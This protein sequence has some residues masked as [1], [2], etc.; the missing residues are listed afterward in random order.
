MLTNAIGLATFAVLA[1][2]HIDVDGM[3]KAVAPA[4]DFFAYTNGTWVKKTTIPADKPGVGLDE[5]LDE[6]ARAQTAELIKAAAAST[7]STAEE[8]KV[9]DYYNT[10]M[11]EAGIE[12]LGK[13]P[14]EGELADVAAIADKKALSR[15]IGASLRADVDALN[16]TDFHTPNLLGVWV[17]QALDDP[18]HN[19][20]YLM[21]GGILMPEREYYVSTKPDMVELRKKYAAHAAAMLKLAGVAKSDD[22]ANAMAA[23]IVALETKI[24]EAHADL[25][26][27]QDVHQPKAVAVADLATTAPGLD[28]SAFFEGARLPTNTKSVWFWQPKAVASLSALVASE[29]LSTWKEWM[30]LHV[31][32]DYAPLLSKA[33][34]DESFK[35]F[36]TAMNGIP[37]QRPR[38]KRAVDGTNGAL[39]F[40]V[41]RMYTAKYF[42]PEAKAKAIAMVEE[43]KKQFAVRIDKLPWMAAATKTKAKEKVATL[44]VGMG[45]PDKKLDYSGLVVVK[46]DAVGNARRAELFEYDRNRA[47]LVSAP[48]RDEW[49]LLPQEVNAMNLPL[50]NTIIFP[51]AI[52]RPPYFDANADPALNFGAMG[53]VIGH[54]ISHSFDDSGSEFDA[55]GRMAR[56]WT[57]DDYA[58]FKDAGKA[59]A[60]QFDKYEVL[61][62][63]HV[64]GAQC[65][66]ENIADVAGLAVAY[67]AWRATLGGAAPNA[68]QLDGFPADQA[69]FIAFGQSWRTKLR[70]DVLRNQVVT[71]SH[72]PALFRVDTVRNIDGFYDAFKPTPKNKLNLAPKDRV[73]IW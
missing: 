45:Y 1:A 14:I 57:D 36:G 71:D 31:V 64:N 20:A 13:K 7:S 4:D 2:G 50:L 6:E 68:K 43:L 15:A 56:W 3:D 23:R 29:P 32:E 63:L 33:F 69:F 21:Q 39:G 41:G 61:P 62:G 59:L 66:S 19:V 16:A 46:G 47:K 24:A 52:L 25:T 44:K 51:A 18:K 48:D 53:A 10:L 54:E 17:A 42:P 28:W 30:Q 72:A 34:V 60:A 38:W 8:K 73:R 22:D 67:D 12:A 37:E 11:D 58:H 5:A 40:A 27:C 70:D 9:G 49:A 26:A 65:L 35:F 55:D